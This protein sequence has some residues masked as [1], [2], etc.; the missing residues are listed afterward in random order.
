MEN[1]KFKMIDEE[2]ECEVCGLLV[3]PLGYSA[4]NHCPRCLSSKHVD[5]NP[6]DRACDCLGI[7]KPI[8]IEP[9]KKGKYKIIY[10]CET[11]A[12]IKK[13]V[14]ATDDNLDEIIKLMASLNN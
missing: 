8:A 14:M 6:G 1:P 5:I 10:R 4:R 2:F 12:E 3:S 13:N 11:C 9:F 7:L